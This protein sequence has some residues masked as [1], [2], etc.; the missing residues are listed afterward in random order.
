[1]ETI[2]TAISI[3]KSL[4]ER[5]QDV[6][7][8]MKVSRSRLFALAL[9]D[10]IRQQENAQLLVEINAAYGDEPDPAEQALRVQS[11]QTHRRIVEGEW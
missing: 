11:R 3:R 5:A 7:R 6:A 4:F 8:K 2:K 1:M 9:E 10:Y